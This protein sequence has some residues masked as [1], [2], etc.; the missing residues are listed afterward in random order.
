MRVGLV[1]RRLSVHGGTERFALGLARA[2]SRGGH[3][4]TVF[5]RGADVEEDGV[6]IVRLPGISGRGRVWKAA[7]LERA[8][9]RVP[10]GSVDVL[11]GFVRAP[12][13]D[14]L[15]AGGGAHAAAIE[16]RV[17]G[18]A[19]RLE[20]ARDTRALKSAGIVVFNSEMARQDALR[21][22]ALDPGRLHVVR[23]GVDLERFRPVSAPQTEGRVLFVG[24][25]WRR[26]GLQTALESLRHLPR[27]RLGV[28]GHDPHAGRY[29]RLA[30]R[31][32][33]AERVDWLGATDRLHQVMPHALALV[34]PTR[35]DP[36]AN[37]C[38]EAMAC[39]VPVVT[40]GRDGAGE[41]L[42]ERWQVV[43]RPDD[44]EGFAG[45]LDR[46]LQTPSL[47]S[48]SRASAE[49]WPQSR[50]HRALAQ[51]AGVPLP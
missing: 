39:G 2:L 17:A 14:L 15:R 44:A 46:V 28:V 30:A 26:K 6:D 51:L 27:L 37:V 7:L 16:G 43:A 42:P 47:R 8:A 12:G 21:H 32:G 38:L 45:A 19:D 25:G 36:S 4:V 5:C 34:L 10:R 33:V 29:R 48:A 9:R 41:I 1:V 18:L 20:L 13:F 23:N 50:A 49:N 22:H 11:L 40:S 35:Y 3:R 31:M 24:H